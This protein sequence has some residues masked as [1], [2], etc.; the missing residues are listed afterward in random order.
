MCKMIHILKKNTC[1]HVFEE[2]ILTYMFL[3]NQYLHLCVCF[4]YFQYFIVI[5]GTLVTF[6]WVGCKMDNLLMTY[7]LCK[8]QLYDIT[9]TKDIWYCARTSS[10]FLSS[11]G[12]YHHIFIEEIFNSETIVL[13]WLYLSQ[14]PLGYVDLKIL[15]KQNVHRC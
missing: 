13:C 6:A 2:S 7:L 3:K 8:C 9:G 5:M 10:Q 1:I 12:I 11:L 15:S 4:I 14:S